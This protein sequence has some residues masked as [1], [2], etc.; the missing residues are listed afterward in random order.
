MSAYGKYT[1]TIFGAGDRQFVFDAAVKADA[2]F[3][4]DRRLAGTAVRIF[5]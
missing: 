4:H 5:M 1:N 2:A 3:H